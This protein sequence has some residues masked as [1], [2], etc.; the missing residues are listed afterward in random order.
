MFLFVD[1]IDKGAGAG[2][3]TDAEAKASLIF[4]SSIF[5]RNLSFIA[6]CL[7]I[8][9][10]V[11]ALSPAPAAIFL[12]ILANGPFVKF[13]M[14]SS[15]PPI[16]LNFSTSVATSFINSSW[17][18]SPLCILFWSLSVIFF[19]IFMS[20]LGSFI[21]WAMISLMDL[22]LVSSFSSKTS[23]KSPVNSSVNS[24][25]NFPNF[26]SIKIFICSWIISGLGSLK[27]LG[28]GP[29]SDEDEDEEEDDS[30][31][32]KPLK[33][34]SNPAIVSFILSCKSFSF[35]DSNIS[36]VSP[37]LAVSFTEPSTVN[38]NS[39]KY[40]H[41]EVLVPSLTPAQLNKSLKS[42]SGKNITFASDS[43]LKISILEFIISKNLSGKTAIKCW[44]NFSYSASSAVNHFSH[45]NAYSGKTLVKSLVKS[46]M[47]ERRFLSLI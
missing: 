46:M 39:C 37:K 43:G 26:P 47:M 5:F 23:F 6:D 12:N 28:K 9:T 1:C 10:T 14:K 2:A 41:M 27:P 15:P 36:N 35:I 22:S 8:W 24:F 3:D 40:F 20:F 18:I 29:L 17:E 44:F 7:P 42:T 25:A 32:P 16:S 33:K 13:L 38:N 11:F 19:I 21:N 30:S 45:K 34:S 4:L 31:D